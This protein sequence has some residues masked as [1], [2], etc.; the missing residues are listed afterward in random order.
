MGVIDQVRCAPKGVLQMLNDL[1]YDARELK[2]L[3]I[4]CDNCRTEVAFDL[5]GTFQAAKV[6][7]PGC[8]QPLL[9][10]G[11]QGEPFDYNL[12]TLYQMFFKAKGSDR[13]RFRTSR[14]AK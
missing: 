2:Q 4:V 6:S 1:T 8:D 9:D 7:C 13:V 14:D 11:R 3:V 10:V 12:I 5:Y